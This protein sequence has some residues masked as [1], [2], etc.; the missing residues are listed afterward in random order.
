[1]SKCGTVYGYKKHIQA[2]EKA[3]TL[4]KEAKRKDSEAYR[5]KSGISLRNK[6]VCGTPNGYDGHRYRN[7]TPCEPCKESLRNY[8]RKKY[9]YKAFLS[10]EC[11]TRG[12]YEK[13]L[14]AMQNPCREC[15]AA[16]ADRARKRHSLKNNV[17]HEQYST[18][19]VLKK[20]GKNCHICKT[21]IDL[22]LPRRVG[23]PGWKYGLH[24]DHKTPISK[25]GADNILNVRP[26]HAICN[27]KKRDRI[28]E[29]SFR[30]R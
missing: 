27:L 22:D 1:M 4:C 12:G 8:K 18:E 17:A 21:P 2:K 10:P 29:E 19:D 6:P 7:E 11:G 24:I 28:I 13:H 15:K 14:R 23:I 25:G 20:Y 9:G 5:R 30:E 16:N 26:S 3:C